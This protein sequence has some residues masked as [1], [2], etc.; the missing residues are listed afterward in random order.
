MQQMSG[1][2]DQ[3]SGQLSLDQ[4]DARAAAVATSPQLTPRP[5]ALMRPRD[6]EDYHRGSGLNRV[7]KLK[8]VKAAFSTMHGGGFQDAYN[9][10]ALTFANTFDVNDPYL[11]NST[12]GKSES[13]QQEAIRSYH[14]EEGETGIFTADGKQAYTSGPEASGQGP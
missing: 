10:G 12:G 4:S 7:K 11:V 13:Q 2:E 14:M 6:R 8:A 3:I 9:T 5:A 1:Q